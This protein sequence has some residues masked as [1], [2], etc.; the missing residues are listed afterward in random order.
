MDRPCRCRS[1]WR[2]CS[3]SSTES[4]RRSGQVPSRLSLTDEQRRSAATS[5]PRAFIIAAP[6]SGKTTV[7]AERYG[8]VRYD[9]AFDSRRILALSFARS[10][11]QELAERIRWRWGT[12]ALAWPHEAVTLDGLHRELV[13]YLLRTGVIQWP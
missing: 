6:G 4:T 13:T 2:R 11:K 8:V 3:I 12:R 5:A 9:G 7:A 1:I 10:A